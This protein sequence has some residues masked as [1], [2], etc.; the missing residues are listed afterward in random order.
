MRDPA[1][2]LGAPR[3]LKVELTFPLGPLAF[4][5]GTIKA[6]RALAGNP[7][8]TD[9]PL[10]ADTL[11]QVTWATYRSLLKCSVLT[12]TFSS[13]PMATPKGCHVLLKLSCS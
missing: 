6:I 10:K 3:C 7:L 4:F 8:L 12:D 5:T 2:R 11:I 13:N 9:P 1:Q